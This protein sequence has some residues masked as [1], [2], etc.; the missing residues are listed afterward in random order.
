MIS[1]TRITLSFIGDKLRGEDCDMGAM[2][3]GLPLQHLSGQVSGGPAE[4]VDG[5]DYEKRNKRK[6]IE[7]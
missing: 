1:K 7:I 2:T 6:K 3:E 5:R 4:G